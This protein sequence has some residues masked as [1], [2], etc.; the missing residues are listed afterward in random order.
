MDLI[1]K[2]DTNSTYPKVIDG[3]DQREIH[4]LRGPNVSKID[5]LISITRV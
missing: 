5:N 3:L 2:N 4:G 1:E